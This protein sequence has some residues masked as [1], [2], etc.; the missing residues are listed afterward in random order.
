MK[1]FAGRWITSFGPMEL[2]QDGDA[3]TG[4][5]WYQGHPC[6]IEG[7]LQG[8]RFVFRYEDSTGGGE[9]WFEHLSYGQIRGQY[10]LDGADQAHPWQGERE[11]DG[12]WDTSFG[13]MRLMQDH[14]RIHG[15]YDGATAGTIEGHLDGTR[16]DFRYQEAG[17]HGAGSFEL[18]EDALGFN[19]IWQPA[20]STQ[21]G[22]WRGVR[23]LPRTGIT[24]LVVI[25]AHW[26][27]SLADRDYSYG[28]MLKEIFARL[29]HVAV[30]QRFFNDEISLARWCREVVYFPEPTIVMIASHGTPQGISVHGRT[31]N[32]KLVID[33]LR[34]APSVQLLHF[35]ACLVMQEDEAGDFARRIETSVPFPISGYTTSVDW[36][37]SAL[38]EFNYLDMILG[39]HCTPEQAAALLPKL[40]TYAGDETPDGCPYVGV[41][42]RFFKGGK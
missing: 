12:I 6:Q 8:E 15:H 5:Y 24:W 41:G 38:V 1:S 3:I 7:S 31:I 29:S 22:L 25:E 28:S 21:Q 2:R 37:G 19:G 30:R 26:Q 39:K 35:S 27:H 36:G 42:F 10:H 20:G 33:H 13:R 4:Q 17:T 9:G 40:V 16:F 32:T 11:W 34:N 14:D 23:V 18:T